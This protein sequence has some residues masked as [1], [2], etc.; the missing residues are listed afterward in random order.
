VADVFISYSR[1]DSGFVH[2]LHDALTSAG[3]DVWVDWEDIPPASRWEQ[4]IDDS[5]DAAESVVFV[6]SGSSLQSEYC[7]LELRHAEKRG[8]RIVPLAIDGASPD[9]APAGLRQ[10]NWIWC[11]GTDDRPATDAIPPA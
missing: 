5:I 7:G 2:E 10:L 3:R 4:D 9:D 8:K 11:R 1:H 6:L